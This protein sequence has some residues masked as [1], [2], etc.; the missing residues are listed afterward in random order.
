MMEHGLSVAS[1]L[2]R[3]WQSKIFIDTTSRQNKKRS[4]LSNFVVPKMGLE[5]IHYR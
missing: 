5:P 2:A 1:D 3:F 4:A